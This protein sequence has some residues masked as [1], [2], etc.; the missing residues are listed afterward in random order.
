VVVPYQHSHKLYPAN[1][2]L[3][4]IL[5]L[6]FDGRRG[7]SYML[8]YNPVKRLVLEKSE[9]EQA[10]MDKFLDYPL[11]WHK[12]HPE[13]ASQAGLAPWGHLPPTVVWV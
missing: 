12:L 4:A 9:V 5:A 10:L 7:D 8:A 11:A 1:P 3:E 2:P 13:A 6:L